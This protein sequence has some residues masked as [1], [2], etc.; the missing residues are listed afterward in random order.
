[1]AK[2]IYNIHRFDFSDGDFPNVGDIASSPLRYYDFGR[3]IEQI[4]IHRTR[5]LRVPPTCPVIV[6]GGGLFYPDFVARIS[7][8]LQ[9]GHVAPIIGWGIGH[10][11]HHCK[12][13]D[14]SN[15]PTAGFKALG[16]RDWGT[17]A[18]WLPC[19]SC[20]HEIFDAAPSPTAEAVVYDHKGFP[21]G[22]A[23]SPWRNRRFRSGGG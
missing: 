19:P 9:S 1:M 20:K 16:V 2:P 14:Y 18:T 11:T 23:N 4:D 15:V 7:E 12:C 8:L 6:G 3:P 10:N 13:V 17:G 21:S 22:Y 5:Q